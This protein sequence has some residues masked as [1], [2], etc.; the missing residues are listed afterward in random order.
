VK[1]RRI[2]SKNNYLSIYDLIL[3]ILAISLL[4]LILI[5]SK[6]ERRTRR[7]LLRTESIVEISANRPG[8]LPTKRD[9]LERW[10]GLT[11]FN[12]Y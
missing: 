11:R 9:V 2:S 10:K 4:G 12:Y 1:E 5:A 6:R 8:G 3:S 7:E